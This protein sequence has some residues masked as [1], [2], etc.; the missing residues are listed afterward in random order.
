[1]MKN[2]FKDSWL[3]AGS[4]LISKDNPK[5]APSFH[6]SIVL[7]TQQEPYNSYRGVFLHQPVIQTEDYDER[8]E[9]MSF[10]HKHGYINDTA[11]IKLPALNGSPTTIRNF[12]HSV[13]GSIP[14]SEKAL[15]TPITMI[16][17]DISA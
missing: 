8:L 15:S 9:V 13:Y 6:Q 16:H 17:N 3:K 10:L 1:M 12:S 2:L 11:E 4:I 5:L 7:L 14:D